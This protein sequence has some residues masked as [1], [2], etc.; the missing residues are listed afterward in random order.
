MLNNKMFPQAEVSQLEGSLEATDT[1]HFPPYLIPDTSCLCDNIQLVKQ[2]TQSGKG[3]LIIP[4]SGKCFCKGI[5]I[6]PIAGRSLKAS[7]SFP[8]LAVQ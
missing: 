3:I 5:L 6:I 7:W 2:L 8:Y 1:P 4:I